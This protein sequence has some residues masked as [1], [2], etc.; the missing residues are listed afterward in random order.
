MGLSLLQEMVSI[1]MGGITGVA[2]GIGAGL[3]DLV[4]NIFTVTGE[5]G[6]VSLSIF[7]AVIC[8][9]GAIALAVGLSRMVVRFLTSFGN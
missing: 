5:G 1:L 6:E 7:G 3:N 2:T 9:F 8:V 4:T